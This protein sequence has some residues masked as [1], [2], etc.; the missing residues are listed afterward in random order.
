MLHLQ[1]RGYLDQISDGK[2]PVTPVSSGP[3]FKFENSLV[4]ASRVPT[5]VIPV[6]Q[7]I[8]HIKVNY[9]IN[10]KYYMDTG[11]TG[12]GTPGAGT[13]GFRDN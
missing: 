6:F 7:I 10:M 12:V 1:D 11:I 13:S 9:Q 5:P 8:F 4:P 3:V 2:P